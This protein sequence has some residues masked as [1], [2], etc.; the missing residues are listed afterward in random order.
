MSILDS[1]AVL[2]GVGEKR[3]EALN[4]LGIHSIIDLLTYYPFRF[5]DLTV[6]SIEDIE[7]NEKVVLEGVAISDGVVS[8][9]GRKRNRLTFRMNCDH[10]IVSVTFFNQPYLKK[11][12]EV[13]KEIKVFGKW[14][15]IRKQLNG[16]K[17]LSTD[18][19]NN[20]EAIYHS[21]KKIRQST[22]FNLIDAAWKVYHEVLPEDLPQAILD[23]HRLLSRKDM[24]YRMHFPNNGTE[25]EEARHSVIFREFFIYQLKMAWMKKQTK[26]AQ[27][28]STIDYDVAQLKLFFDS[29][30][31]ELTQ[32]QKRVV[33]EVCKD[34]KIPG[35]MFRLLQGDVGSGKTV[36]AASAILAAKTAGKQSALMAPTEILA[37]QHKQSLDEMF[38]KIEIKVALLTG[39]TKRKKREMIL[40]ELKTGELDCIIGTHALIQDDV[41]FQ[42]LGLVI[43]DEQHRF[44]VN[45]R[46]TLREKGFNPDVLFMTATPIPRTLSI[47]AYGEMDVSIIDEMPVGRKPISTYWIRPKHFDRMTSFL[48]K[49]LA[50]G[51]Q[52]YIISPL[53][54]ES[55]MLD[56]E[57]VT[58]LYHTY[59][60]IL[61]DRYT[62]GLLHGRMNPSE[63]ETTM[64]AFQKNDIQVLVSTTVIEVGVNVPN[65]TLMIIHDADRFGLAQLHQLRGRVGRGDQ[66]S[67]CILIADPKGEKGA[68]RM[69]IIT[70][71]SDGFVLSQRD[72]EMRGPGDVF[73]KKQSG[74]PE[75][76]V[77]D[78][79]EDFEILEEARSAAQNLIQSTEF[80]AHEEYKFLRESLGIHS[81]SEM[82]LD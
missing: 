9:F 16:M 70:E 51:N 29:L 13:G 77:A 38:E 2:K 30:P 55:E 45:Q 3:V 41:E 22:I 57:N 15:G 4:E 39:S 63:K 80:Y 64:G 8:H 50:K 66:E 6:K 54:E 78:I 74:L 37:T 14:D 7:D 43:T 68:E 56:L 20:R 71:T 40:E 10:V 59:K 48:K 35:Q 36:V 46:K 24:I 44:G 23:K 65:A 58:A 69:Q 42:S 82:I 52:V 60:E 18:L 11:Q 75:F 62:V 72:L 73:G 17:I 76:K 34:L 32:A 47:T 61:D 5:E 27:N 25:L 49:E 81:N 79:V 12:V 67:Y 33:N 31:Y 21:S 19:A 53:I 26:L 1:I 28:G